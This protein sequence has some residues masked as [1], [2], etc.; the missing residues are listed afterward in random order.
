MLEGTGPVL[1]VQNA[2]EPDG[3]FGCWLGFLPRLW[4]LA[5]RFRVRGTR[6]GG[7]VCCVEQA[8]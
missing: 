7:S 8:M 3:A 5:M 2:G 6:Q 4:L 1:G